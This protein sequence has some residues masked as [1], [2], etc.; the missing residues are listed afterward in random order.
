M[1]AYDPWSRR[2]F[3]VVSHVAVITGTLTWERS[4]LP[5]RW[6]TLKI[7]F[8]MACELMV[9]V[10]SPGGHPTR[11]CELFIKLTLRSCFQNVH[12]RWQKRWAHLCMR[13]N[14]HQ[15]TS[16]CWPVLLSCVRH[17]ESV[18]ITNDPWLLVSFYPTMS[19]KLKGL[20][21]HQKIILMCRVVGCHKQYFQIL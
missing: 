8:D 11:L 5:S 18:V 4:R 19:L 10:V 2:T 1:H 17:H 12:Y 13:V 16:I 14:T 7:H 9:D 20:P 6:P 15:V 3:Q 21:A